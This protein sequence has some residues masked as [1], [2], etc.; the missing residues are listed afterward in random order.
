MM[1]VI[2]FEPERRH[3][4]REVHATV[5]RGYAQKY[6]MS[7]NTNID[8]DSNESG[9]YTPFSTRKDSSCVHNLEVYASADAVI[10]A[11]SC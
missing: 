9:L 5:V 10:L 11:P 6:V 1:H 4:D 3:R 7:L 2:R 8:V